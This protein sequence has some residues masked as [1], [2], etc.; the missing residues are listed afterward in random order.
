MAD[1]Y[2]VEYND[3]APAGEYGLRARWTFTNAAFIAELNG[4]N[5]EYLRALVQDDI[6][7]NTTL[8]IKAQG[9]IFG[10]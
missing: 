1:M 9:R 7:A 10:A 3:K 2:D 4:D 6:T 8:K 5:G